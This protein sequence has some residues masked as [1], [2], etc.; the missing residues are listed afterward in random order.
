M[1]GSES[2]MAVFMQKYKDAQSLQEKRIWETAAGLH[3]AYNS[4]GGSVWAERQ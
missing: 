1:W 2:K 4:K 3:A